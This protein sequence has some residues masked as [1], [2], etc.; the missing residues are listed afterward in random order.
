MKLIAIKYTPQCAYFK[1]T[2]TYKLEKM[3][4]LI[5]SM[6]ERCPGRNIQS[7]LLDITGLEGDIPTLDRFTFGT[8]VAEQN[9]K[10]N[11]SL[12]VLDNKKNIDRF[13]ETVAVNRGVR[14]FMTSSKDKAVAWLNAN[15]KYKKK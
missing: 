6:Y 11:I 14:F 13:A 15:E 8:C 12:A 4:E 1:L 3:M 7:L 2:G 5:R 10:N 9:K